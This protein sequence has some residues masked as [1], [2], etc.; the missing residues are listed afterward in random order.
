MGPV[1]QSKLGDKLSQVIIDTQTAIDAR[2]NEL[3]STFINNLTDKLVNDVRKI[4]NNE[5]LLLDAAKSMQNCIEFNITSKKYNGR[6]EITVRDLG[7]SVRTILAEELLQKGLTLTI[8]RC[9][10]CDSCIP[11]HDNDSCSCSTCCLIWGL[12]ILVCMPI[13]VPLFGYNLYIHNRYRIRVQISWQYK[14]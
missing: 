8:E 5:Q 4:I 11:T 12:G 13:A 10:K 1:E 7:N 2:N 9:D 14:K 6:E 3:K